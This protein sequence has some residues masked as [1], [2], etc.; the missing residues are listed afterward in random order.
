MGESEIIQNAMEGLSLALHWPAVGFLVLGVLFGLFFGAVPGL[1][2]LTGLA[3]LLPFTFGMDP[4]SAFAVLLGMYAVTTTS[5]VIPTILMGVP[6][7]AAAAATV[8]D[9]YPMA[10]RGEAA[11]AFGAAFTSGAFGGVLGGVAM[12]LS[13]PVV[14]PLVLSFAKPEFFMLGVL[15]ITMVG[16]LSGRSI[17]KGLISGLLGLVIGTVGY[18]QQIAIPRYWMGMNFLL[19][20]VPLIPLI[21]GLFAL[22]EIVGIATRNRT[23]SDIPRASVT[24]GVLTG[25]KDVVENWWLLLRSSVIGIYIG[26][27]PGLGPV[28]ADWVAY[29]HAVQSVK[30][31]PNFG[32]G[33]VRGVI[34]PEA[35]NHSVKGGDLI[36]TVAFGIPTSAGMAILLGAFLI[37]GLTPGPEM[38]TTKLSLTFSMVWTLIIANVLA[39]ILLMLWTNQ[40]QKIIFISGH[41]VVPAIVLCMFMG[42]WEGNGQIGQW[43]VLLVFCVIGDVMKRGGWPRAPVMLGFILE[44]IMENSLNLSIASYGMGWVT[45]PIV[46]VIGGAALLTVAFVIRNQFRHKNDGGVTQSMDVESHNPA[47]SLPFAIVV[48]ALLTYAVIDSFG[49]PYTVRLYPEAISVPAL[50]FALIVVRRDALAVRATLPPGA[51]IWQALRPRALAGDEFGR[52]VLF[53]LWLVGVVLVTILAGQLVALPLFIFAYLL[54]WGKAKLW[55]AAL[56]AALGWAFLY[57]VFDQIV[58]TFWYNSILFG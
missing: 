49:W 46:M 52:R 57:I 17:L 56:Y 39:T 19:D 32:N 58:S 13:I 38:L 10:K 22:P 14:R 31:N 41:M 55:V 8:L 54:V 7:S 4:V 12:G 35:A 45:R 18:A 9:G 53:Y 15:G 26:L 40:L 50:L 29:G 27:I 16:S 24:S 34:A 11:R 28:V 21:L 51:S 44:P 5:D 1:G 33:D 23:I 3:I 20:G 6:A 37:Q 43:W 42:A 30:K 36:P 48:C 2:G 47:I 25:A